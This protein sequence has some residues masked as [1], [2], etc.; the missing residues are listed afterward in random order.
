MAVLLD[1]GDELGEGLFERALVEVPEHDRGHGPLVL[2][3]QRHVGTGHGNGSWHAQLPA[4]HT[5]RPT[6]VT[7][8]S[9]DDFIA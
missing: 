6:G 8:M 3:G 5:R 9:R 4:L 1:E 7:P 2:D